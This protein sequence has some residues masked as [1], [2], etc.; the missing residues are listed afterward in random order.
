MYQIF[1]DGS[2]NLEN[3]FE[4]FKG[5]A[6]EAQ[7]NYNQHLRPEKV[8]NYMKLIKEKQVDET[9]HDFFAYILMI[10]G[11]YL[12]MMS[13]FFIFND[14]PDQIGVMFERFN[15]D[16]SSLQYSFEKIMKRDLQFIP[17]ANISEYTLE[18]NQHAHD[19][20]E[21]SKKESFDEKIQKIKTL[22]PFSERKNTG[23]KGNGVGIDLG[24]T[25][26]C[27]AIVRNGKVEIIPNERGNPITPSFVGFMNDEVFIGDSAKA[28]ITQNP[29]NTL[30]DAKSMIGRTSEQLK[31]SKLINH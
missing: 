1:L 5:Y 29:Q 31:T 20:C 14:S 12:Q 21:I 10:H 2:C 17:A 6:A 9:C 15:K 23:Q 30:F 18:E 22:V 16:F 28:R 8:L 3:T 26:C 27:A 4:L 24:T 11:K 25:Y 7:V 19:L 13:L